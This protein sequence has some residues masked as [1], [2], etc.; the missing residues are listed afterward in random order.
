MQPDIW[1]QLREKLPFGTTPEQTQLRKKIWQGF[2]V[3]GNGYLSLA[4]VDKGMRDVV[5]LPEMFSLKPVLIRA[6]NSAKDRLK[7]K[8]SYGDDY[9]SR[10]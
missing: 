9:V 5:Q 7:S 8:N 3:N 1:D 6:F 4:E 10:A 2:D